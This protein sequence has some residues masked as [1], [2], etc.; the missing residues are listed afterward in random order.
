[1]SWPRRG[2]SSSWR[3]WYADFYNAYRQ[4]DDRE[5]LGFVRKVP[6]A[7]TAGPEEAV[8]SRF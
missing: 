1:M 8:A 4:G 3:Y 6:E 7:A 5:A 2:R